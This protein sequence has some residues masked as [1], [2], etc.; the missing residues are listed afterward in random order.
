VYR[1]ILGAKSILGEFNEELVAVDGDLT[2]DERGDVGEIVVGVV[3]RRVIV[4]VK[5]DN[6]VTRTSGERIKGATITTKRVNGGM[7]GRAT[8]FPRYLP[9]VAKNCVVTGVVEKHGGIEKRSTEQHGSSVRGDGAT[10]VCKGDIVRGVTSDETPGADMA[11]LGK[12]VTEIVVG[13]L[14][15]VACMGGDFLVG[16]SGEIFERSESIDI[17][18]DVSRFA[19]R[20]TAMNFVANQG[21]EFSVTTDINDVGG[22][23]ESSVQKDRIVEQTTASGG[24][25]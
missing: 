17:P 10:K 9:M 15:D 22:N 25:M 16:V 13:V 8:L 19:Q 5:V 2:R 12:F 7:T 18:L 4:E 1:K 21:V 3:E 14:E 24:G 11:E 20:A 23:A 6:T